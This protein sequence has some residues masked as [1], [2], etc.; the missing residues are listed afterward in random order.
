MFFGH[1]HGMQKLL[2]RDG[3]LYHCCNHSHSSDNTRSLTPRAPGNALP[4][5]FLRRS[6]MPAGPQLGMIPPDFCST[7]NCLFFFALDKSILCVDAPSS[8]NFLKIIYKFE[9]SKIIYM[10]VCIYIYIYM[11]AICGR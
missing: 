10:C 6:I 1:A 9:I 3:N 2:G 7:E 8:G 11:K 5:F 4:C